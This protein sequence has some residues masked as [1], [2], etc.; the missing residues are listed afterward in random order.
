MKTYAYF[1]GCSL[2]RMARSYHVS[3]L[4]AAHKLGLEFKEVEDWNCCGATAYFHV[5][6]L[7]AYTLC[8]RNLALAEREGA[9]LVAPCSGCFKNMYFTN[10][11]LKK[12]PELTEHV[13]AALEADGLTFSGTTK[14]RHLLS[15]FVDDVGLAEIKARVTH[16][17]TGLRVAPYYGCQVLR[18]QKN[19][20]D[21]EQPYFFED[22]LS[23]IGAT[24]A[25]YPT[26]LRC[27][28]G[29]LIVTN[30]KAAL[31]MVRDLLQS[32][33]DQQAQVIATVCPLC[34]INL[35]CY[36]RHVNRL[37]RTRFSV[38]VLYFT[39][40]MGLALGVPAR[41]LGVGTELTPA[42]AVS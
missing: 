15:V 41:R 19:G 18:P 25:A 30:R 23:A 2:E 31:A 21:I 17:L 29:S 22:L 7:L 27:C 13:N 39:Q 34:Q 10:A 1:P 42:L 37:F 38:P 36:Q 8:A 20:E 35:E 32:A 40:L 5:D 33:V 16:P 4:E 26:R 3:T 9:D 11:H 14:V 12:E 6:E 28:G 24:P